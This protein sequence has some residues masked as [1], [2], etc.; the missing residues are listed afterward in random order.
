MTN[1]QLGEPQLS[2]TPSAAD[3][4]EFVRTLVR[5]VGPGFHPDTDF[6]DYVHCGNGTQ[7]FP[8]HQADRLNREIDRAIVVLEQYEENIYDIAAPIQYS[9]LAGVRMSNALG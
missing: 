9:L 3:A 7:S 8:P 1:E 4:A 2:E 5:W 6:N